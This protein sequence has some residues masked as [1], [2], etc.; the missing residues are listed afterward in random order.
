MSQSELPKG[1]ESVEM[2]ASRDIPDMPESRDRIVQASAVPT[3][4]VALPNHQ[5]KQTELLEFATIQ[6]ALR[7]SEQRYRSLVEAIAQIIWDTNAEGKFVTEQPKWAAFTGQNYQEY[8]GWGWLNAIHP[9]DQPMTVKIWKAALA[10]RSL[11]EIEYRV[12]RFDGEYRYLNGRAVPVIEADGTIREWVGINA[13]ITEHKQAEAAR[14][15][16]LIQAELAG[17]ELQGVFMQAPAAIATFR[18]S[19]HL[20]ETVNLQ[21]L[22]LV[23]SDANILG[24]TVREAFSE[25]EGQA[26]FELLDQ[27]YASGEAFVGKEMRVLWDGNSDQAS[28]PPADQY[29][30]EGFWNVVYQPLRDSE[31]KVYGIM[32]H[33]VEVT[34]Q[35]R[36][37]QDIEKK[38]EELAH[39]TQAL[40]RSNQDLD[41]FAYV[42]SHDLKAPLRAIA[43]LSEWI[44]D[45]LNEQLSEDSREHLHL[46]RK[47]VHR[48]G[49]LIDGILQYSRAG[50]V[51][52]IETVNV[53]TLLSDLIEFLAP[54][55][56]IVFTIESGMPTL[57]T[58]KI[59]LE[60]VFMNLLS[61]AIK[62]VQD[63][64]PKIQVSVKSS[65][66][67]YQFTV[68]D[69]GFGIAPEFHNK[70]WGIFQ[71]L[72][73]R[74]KVEGT[75]VGLSIVKKIVE[76]RGGRVWVESELGAGAS[77]CFTWLKQPSARFS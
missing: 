76:S 22:K 24:K 30:E 69:N 37:R 20:I 23:G 62:Y 63:S 53:G 1:L 3:P 71:R 52:Q 46:M 44:E 12:R 68:T 10:N 17:A 55:L 67:Y 14:D 77:F 54:P 32:T 40:K 45:D 59:P 34:E 58:E 42:T 57:K 27:V 43:N 19:N 31:G 73:A 5:D 35:V 25:V 7:N 9:E 74:D 51:Q 16:A 50:R 65:G 41:Q 29:L 56:N 21:Y 75:G 48:M 49:A 47:R 15:R 36:S 4:L 2:L 8:Q 61:N 60:Q 28:S 72:E 70:I 13:D 33:A 6:E 11:Y 18:G 66:K 64:E 26:L 39:L 38:A